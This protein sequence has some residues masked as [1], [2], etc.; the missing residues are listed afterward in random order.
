[1]IIKINFTGFPE[2]LITGER[3]YRMT[4]RITI[5]TVT[6][7]PIIGMTTSNHTGGV[8]LVFLCGNDIVHIPLPSLQNMFNKLLVALLIVGNNDDSVTL[9]RSK[10]DKP[11]IY[12]LAICIPPSVGNWHTYPVASHL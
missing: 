6:T 10:S 9:R 7:T 11:V 1:M 12:K 5:A 4:F 2:T 3:L 8:I